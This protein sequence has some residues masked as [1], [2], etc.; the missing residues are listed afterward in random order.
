MVAVLKMP[1][2]ATGAERRVFPRKEVHGHL[3]GM[4]MDHSIQALQEPCLTLS[5][6]DISYGGCSA[7]T[8]LPLNLGERV[9]IFF[10]PEGSTRGWDA[11]GRV[12]RCEPSALGYRV[13]VEFD[14]LQAA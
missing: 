4:R 14:P 6:R 2:T 5:M 1:E 3:Q 8:Q 13:A 7:L 12:L 9:S 11:C 10:P